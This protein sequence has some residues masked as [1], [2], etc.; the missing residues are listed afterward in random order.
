MCENKSFLGNQNESRGWELIGLKV[1]EGEPHTE[2]R[3]R[4]EIQCY[5]SLLLYQTYNSLQVTCPTR[6]F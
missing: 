4:A 3:H 2:L 5:I 6:T 1:M